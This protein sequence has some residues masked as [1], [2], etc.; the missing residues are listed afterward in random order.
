MRARRRAARVCAFVALCTLTAVACKDTTINQRTGGDGK[1]CADDSTCADAG[2]SGDKDA[3]SAGATP[4]GGDSPDS[5]GTD[6]DASEGGSVAGGS[7]DR[8]P[9]S[10][11]GTGA[12]GSTGREG[13]SGSVAGEA[14]PVR[15]ELSGGDLPSGLKD[16]TDGCWMGTCT[17]WSAGN[18]VIGDKSFPTGFDITCTIGCGATDSGYFQVRTSRKYTK[19]DATFGI[20]ADSPGNDKTQ[21]LALKVTDQGTGR[22]LYERA[23][24]YGRSYSL[25]GF[26][27]SRVALLRISFEG[28]LAATHG[29]V[30]TPVVRR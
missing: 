9:D 20:A 1:V 16:S 17:D 18:V 29:A 26:D 14:V 25:T 22:V 24:E 27:I 3:S 23:L 12:D 28:P 10:G 8:G 5:P 11:G 4:A 21:T 2:S 30:G 6:T 13:S 7:P 19:F 15:V